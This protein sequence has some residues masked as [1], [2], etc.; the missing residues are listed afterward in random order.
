MNRFFPASYRREGGIG[1][2]GRFQTGG[3]KPL[4]R[5]ADA[6][7]QIGELLFRLGVTPHTVGYAM[8]RDGVMLLSDGDRYRQMQLTTELYPLLGES[9][10]KKTGQAEH[11]M[12][13]AVRLA[14]QKE[15]AA[16]EIPYIG[17]E[18]PSNAAL[19]YQL[20]VCLKTNGN[21]KSR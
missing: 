6:R 15:G 16:S 20:A 8:L 7:R 2:E 13:D 11:A 1:M 19:L 21:K 14:W 3:S 17:E 4:R 10:Q 12:R 5:Y 18:T 9:A